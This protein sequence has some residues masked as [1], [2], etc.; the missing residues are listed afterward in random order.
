MLWSKVTGLGSSCLPFR[1]PSNAVHKRVLVMPSRF[2]SLLHL[3]GYS[4]SSGYLCLHELV[5]V[6]PRE[7]YVIRLKACRTDTPKCERTFVK[8]SKCWRTWS[9]G[10]A[11]SSR[12]WCEN[13]IMLDG[14]V[15]RACCKLPKHI[16]V[17]SKH[18]TPASNFSLNRM[19]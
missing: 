2:I 12:Q 5:N 10:P 7:C 15:R 1:L 17:P 13:L 18:R 4:V 11:P 14:E 9:L 16:G 6:D 8:N 3:G 19:C